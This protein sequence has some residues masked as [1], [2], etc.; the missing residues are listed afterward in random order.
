MLWCQGQICN[1]CCQCWTKLGGSCDSQRGLTWARTSDSPSQN[2]RIHT[3]PFFV[4]MPSPR[5]GSPFLF[6]AL[7]SG[8]RIVKVT[9]SSNSTS[10][11]SGGVPKKKTNKRTKQAKGRERPKPNWSKKRDHEDRRGDSDIM[12]RSREMT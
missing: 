7:C 2:P 3:P 12:N 5:L 10:P 6:F 8:F 1:L 11:S 4:P 9:L